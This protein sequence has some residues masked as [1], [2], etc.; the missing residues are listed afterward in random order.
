MGGV[1]YT[2]GSD[3]MPGRRNNA[4]TGAG[5]DERSVGTLSVTDAVAVIA[6]V[7]VGAG[8]FRCPSIVAANVGSLG[9]LVAAWLLGGAISLVG[10]LCYAELA[11]AFAHPGGEYHLLS[12]A[13]GRGVG[14]L[15]AWARLT[16]IQTGSIAGLAFVF[17]DYVAGLLHNGD[18][19]CSAAY[20]GGCVAVLTGLNV[21][22]VR[23]GA[24]AQKLLTAAKV[25]GLALVGS[26]ALLAGGPAPT[27][28]D[29]GGRVAA[30]TG[31]FGLALVFVLFTF[32]GWNEAAY[33]AAELK[34]RRHGV[35]RALVA[36]VLGIA[37]LYAVVNLAYVHVLGLRGV[38]D[39]SA[40]AADVMRRATG[41]LGAAV[42]GCL[43]ALAALGATNATILTGARAYYALGR[44]HRLLG[45]M[46]TWRAP[47]ATPASGL[48]VQGAVTLAV[49]AA[50]A[51]TRK[52]FQTMV[53]YTA[54][55][56]W[57][58]FLLVGA[59]VI[60][61]R[62]REPHAER[63]FRVPLYPLTPVLFCG[64]CAFMLH[65]A[66]SYAGRGALVGLAV[67]AVGVPVWLACR[68]VGGRGE[69]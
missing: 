47:G 31:H 34:D 11:S 3:N 65:A 19:V 35:V 50:G 15:F 13:Y 37:V 22:G 26:A 30:G 7:V 5:P 45:F 4:G 67:L 44:D 6:G 28:G 10:A 27:P 23:Q 51:V 42:T 62:V 29:A 14:F 43:V 66:V 20:A 9:A 21:V 24:C 59:S 56:F 12:R 33:I 61:L 63:S 40:V 69:V 25:L 1:N 48:I 64:A 52:G 2:R 58:F 32:G 46:G 54:P 38:A 49:V 18:A 60:A 39:S 55:V 53:D 68:A 16:V 41:D 17:G 57:L 8:I 36:S